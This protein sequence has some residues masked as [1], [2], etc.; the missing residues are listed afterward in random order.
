MIDETMLITMLAHQTFSFAS[1]TIFILIAI[2][3]CGKKKTNAPAIAGGPVVTPAILPPMDEQKTQSVMD[4]GGEGEKKKEEE[5]VESAKEV[6]EK[7]ESK[8]ESSKKEGSKKEGSKK[9]GSPQ[10]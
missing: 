6:G 10:E 8:K 1:I 3:Q 9:E 5:K 4:E 2:I 7:K